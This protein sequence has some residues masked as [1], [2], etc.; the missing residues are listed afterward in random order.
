MSFN[1]GKNIRV[2][3]FGESHGEAIGVV[4]DGLPA[5]VRLNLSTLYDFLA[6]RRPG[7]ALST[8]R[9]EADTPKI[10]SGLLDGVLTGAPI[11]AVIHNTDVKSG[12]YDALKNTPRPGH[13]DYPAALRFG[14]AADM[15]GGGPFSGR[16]TAPLCIAGG[17]CLQLLAEKGVAVTTN[18]LEIAGK[19]D[20]A[21]MVEA[22]KSTAAQ[23]DSV[24]GIVEC[25]A[26]GLA[27][28]M[29][30]HMF[31]GVENRVAA[32]VFGV[33]GVRGIEFGDGFEAARKRGSEHNDAYILQDGCVVTETNHCGGVLGGMTT[34]NDLV[35]RVALKPTPSISKIQRTVNLET[36]KETEISISGR[37]DPC[38]VWRAAPAIEAAAAIA[39]L[40]MIF[41]GRTTWK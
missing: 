10:L 9:N 39:L 31:D 11:C 3:I 13:A 16:L 40:D 7:G 38:I 30:G 24:G 5:G 21:D 33:P 4:I 22:V 28:G 41:D 19:R 6:R 23:G 25:R 17:I 12:D 18:V 14:G 36:M 32:A 2:S 35:F 34:G 26:K 15:R 20:P 27:P 1:F 37:H 8:A 29:G